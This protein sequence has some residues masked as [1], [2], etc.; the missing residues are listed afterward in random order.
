MEKGGKVGEYK[1]FQFP[2][3]VFGWRQGCAANSP[4]HQNR[5]DPMKETK[6]LYTDGF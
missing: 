5:P 3:F 2:L 1:I 6:L 4:T